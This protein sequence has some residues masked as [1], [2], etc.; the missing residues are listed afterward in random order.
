MRGNSAAKS[1]YL[2]LYSR[3]K[4]DCPYLLNGCVISICQKH[5]LSNLKIITND[6]FVKQGKQI[7]SKIGPC[8]E[9]GLVDSL[10]F[11]L[12]ERSPNNLI[13]LRMLLRAF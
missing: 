4:F 2:S 10:R 8:K 12:K 5:N 13:L 7:M 6:A 1:F 11:V 9:N 3:N